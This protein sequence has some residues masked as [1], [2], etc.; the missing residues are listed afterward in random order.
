MKRH[1]RSISVVVA[2]SLLAFAGAAPTAEAHGG[3]LLSGYGTP[4]EGNQALLGS[5]LLGGGGSTGGGSR[6][7]GSGGGQGVA[8]AAGLQGAGAQASGSQG[9]STGAGGPSAVGTKTSSAKGRRRSG[10][11]SQPPRRSSQ[12][13]AAG[14]SNG[15]H[16]LFADSAHATSASVPTLGITGT[17][18]L[19]IL[20]GVGGLLLTGIF[21]RQLV[22]RP[23]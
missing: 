20:L 11:A 8:Q 7:G 21:T 6:S 18:L 1:Q 22:R 16:T 15:S 10:H 3:T 19:Y 12:L 4:G 2:V 23:Q 9:A 17:D 14:T 13:A 5:A